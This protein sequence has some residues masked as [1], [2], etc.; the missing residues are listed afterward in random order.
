MENAFKSIIGGGDDTQKAKARDFV[1][2]VTT[3]DPLSGF[4]DD[5]VRESASVLKQLSP[6]QRERA[7]QHSVQNVQSNIKESD[8]SSL[9]DMLKQRQSGEGMVDITRSGENVEPGAAQSGGGGG[10]LDDL[11][12][13]LLGGGGGGGQSGGGGGL[14]GILGGLLGGGGGD[15]QSRGGGGLDDVLGGLLGGGGGSQTGTVEQPSDADSGFLGEI[16]SGPMGK[17]IIAGAAAYAMK[18]ILDK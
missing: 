13:G 1:D 2:R 8:R 16:L 17:A 3:G 4:D 10:G 11:L 5:E 6:E 14:G 7:L 12:G 9:N 15:S 18:E